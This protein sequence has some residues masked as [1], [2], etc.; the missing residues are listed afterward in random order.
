MYELEEK[1]YLNKLFEG[2]Y[3]RT[4]TSR[5]AVSGKL[6]HIV[7]QENAEEIKNF[8]IDWLKEEKKRSVRLILEELLE[9]CEKLIAA[10]Q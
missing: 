2:R 8:T 9:K 6:L 7:N 10:S 5:C 3:E 4:Y 1:Q